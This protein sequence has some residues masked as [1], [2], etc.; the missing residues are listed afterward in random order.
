VTTYTYTDKAERL[1]EVKGNANTVD[2]TY[3]LDGL[4]RTQVE[5]KPNATLVSDHSI[6]YDLNGNR[7]RDVTRKMN[8]DNHGAV[9][10]TTADYTYDPRDRVAAVT[11]TGDGAGSETYVHDA[12]N[13]VISQTVAGAS[14][15]FNYDRNRL[16]TAATSGVTAAHNYDPFGRLDTI[17]DPFTGNRYGFG[18]GNPISNIEIDG[19]MLVA[20]DGGGGGTQ[21]NPSVAERIFN[22]VVGDIGGSLKDTWNLGTTSLRCEYTDNQNGCDELNDQLKRQYTTKEGWQETWNAV[23][24]PFVNDCTSMARA[25][26]CAGHVVAAVVEALAGK[27]LGRATR[28]VPGGKHL[29]DCHSFDPD[30]PVVM[31]DG[32]TKKI[33]DV[34]VGDKV[35]ATDPATGK[36]AARTVTALHI[37]QDTDLTDIT[38]RTPDGST[39]VLRTTQQHR[40]WDATTRTWVDAAHL[41]PGHALRTASGA[42]L[43]TV[44]AIHNHPGSHQMRDLTVVTDHTYYVIA[45]DTPVLVHNCGEGIAEASE[46]AFKAAAD[47][48]KIFVKNKHLAS[49]G[50]NIAKFNSND[51]PEVQRWVAE[52]LRSDRAVFLPAKDGSFQI[53]VDMG[54]QVGTKG[55]TGIR[56][57]VD[58]EGNVFNAFSVNIG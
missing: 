58:F 26:E 17:T 37:N 6:D 5:K 36:T 7:S 40:F 44:V 55:Q 54:R 13:N 14:T 18:G 46:A 42:T 43:T 11:K 29:P 35:L 4:L 10:T 53:M 28:L 49:F 8:A 38:I 34:K 15:T 22:T 19:H 47:P 57:M 30:T 51:I 45:G 32:S 52:G 27:G 25:P 39:A 23:K 1:R 2:Y 21:T 12:N 41:Q 50:G 16:L 24:E 56:V 9:L 48:S 33:K 3:F 20:D 31:A